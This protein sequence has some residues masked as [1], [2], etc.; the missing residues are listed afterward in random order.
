MDEAREA[1]KRIENEPF[2]PGDSITALCADAKIVARAYITKCAEAERMREALVLVRSII[3][4][5][6]NTGFNWKDGDWAERLFKSQA[7]TFAA[8]KETSHD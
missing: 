2:M 4:D 1:A 5:A 8:L 7:D 6:A 3:K